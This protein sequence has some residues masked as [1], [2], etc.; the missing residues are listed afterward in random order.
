MG[1]Y[2]KAVNLNQHKK[3]LH[4]PLLPLSEKWVCT[5]STQYGCSMGCKF[6]DV[7]KVGPGRNAT[8]EDLIEEV[9]AVRGMHKDVEFCDRFN[10]HYA[11]M[12]EPTWNRNVIDSAIIFKNDMPSFNVHPVISTMMPAHNKDLESFIRAWCHVKND[13]YD[14]EAGLQLSINST[15]E[16]ERLLMFS[17][18]SLTLWG[19]S[20]VMKEMPDPVGR[21]YTLNF[22]IAGYEI[23]AKKLA[24]LFP[25]SRFIC[26]LTPM[27][28]TTTALQ[29]GIKT[30]GDYTESY[31]YEA[32]EAR[33][34][35]AGF[36][37]LVFIA[38]SEEDSSGITCGNAILSRRATA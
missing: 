32:D 9:Y 15:D 29:N 4:G 20:E 36:E 13:Y 5:I 7:P 38:S 10:I 14:G 8:L 11:R 33:L 27:H 2:G 16:E 6:C 28:K 21:K 12:G 31:P 24:K 17:N 25:P 30:Q 26:K 18:N 3:V 1:D 34:R 37:T 22:A 23:D 19:I 35:A